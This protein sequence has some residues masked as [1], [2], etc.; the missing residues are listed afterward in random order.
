MATYRHKEIKR[1]R[2]G[3]F[4][5]EN[6]ELEIDDEDKHAEFL[7]LLA[8]QPVMESMGI[9]EVD[10][11]AEAKSSVSMAERLKQ[12]GRVIKGIAQGSNEIPASAL[13]TGFADRTDLN[14]MALEQ[15][16][17]D[18]AAKA[19]A[20]GQEEDRK[21][22][23]ALAAEAKRIEEEQLAAEAK[24]KEAAEVEAKRLAEEKEA[25]EAA[26]AK[27]K[28]DEDSKKAAAAAKFKL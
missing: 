13:G 17:K 6:H 12:R 5:F 21:L 24:V 22:R 8:R 1:Y 15:A 27:A 28:A 19:L 16:Q 20:E 18:A 23:E 9:F 26:V 3:D 7:E 11:V 14:R 2:L 4:Q 25:A 10:K